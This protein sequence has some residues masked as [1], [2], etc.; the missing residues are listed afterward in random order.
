MVYKHGNSVEYYIHAT[1][2]PNVSIPFHKALMKPL[3]G[4]HGLTKCGSLQI[5]ALVC[6]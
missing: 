2:S 1:E 5:Q 6:T 4:A 3:L